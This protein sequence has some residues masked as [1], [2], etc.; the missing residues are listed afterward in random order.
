MTT[1]YAKLYSVNLIAFIFMISKVEPLTQTDEKGE[2]YF[3][4]ED[5]AELTLLI[6]IY[7][8]NHVSVD[9]KEYLTSFRHIRTLMYEAKKAKRQS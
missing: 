4:Y 6:N 7:R 9:L 3:L 2:V 1:K 5:S 8:S